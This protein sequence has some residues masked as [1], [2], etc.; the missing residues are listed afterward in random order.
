ME[1][2]RFCRTAALALGLSLASASLALAGTLTV[3]PGV[4]SVGGL[5]RYTGSHGLEIDVASPDRNPAFVQSSHPSAEATY[6]VRFYVNLRGLTMSE[7]DEFEVF[8]A[9]DGTDPV[10]PA[11]TGNALLRVVARRSGGDN[12]LSAFVRTDGGSQAEIPDE[13]L[14]VDGW[15]VIELNWAK[16]TAAGANNG[17]LDLWVDGFSQAGLSS[18]DNDTASINYARWGAVSGVDNGTSGTLKLDDFAS[19]RSGYIGPLSVFPDVPASATYW[20]AV[21]GLYSAEITSGCGGGAYCPNSLVTRAEMAAFLLRARRG[22]AFA[23][24]AASGIFS[25]VS[26]GFWAAPWIE[27]LYNDGLTTGCATSPLQY[28]PNNNVNRAEMAIFLL[29]AKYG[30]GYTPPPATGLFTDVPASHWAAPWIEQLYD[31]NITTG[32]GTNPLRYCPGDLATRWQMAFFLVRTF[33]LPTQQVG[34]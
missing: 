26:I 21:Q 2:T 10:P 19:Q 3:R 34:P 11:I 15:R 16:A 9:Y 1:T 29:R 28:C 32:C 25:D 30:P 4:P 14:L 5:A 31:E 23:P 6:R 8:T 24:P 12:V 18:L 7:G 27:Q 33:G 22:P 20:G 17:R 13:I